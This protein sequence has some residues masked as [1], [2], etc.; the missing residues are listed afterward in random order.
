[1]KAF[2]IAVVT[3]AATVAVAETQ[4]TDLNPQKGTV[5]VQIKPDGTMNAVQLDKSVT[6]DQEA[7]EAAQKAN[8]AA[9]PT[10]KI[11]YKSPREEADDSQPTPGWYR[12]YSGWVAA[13][14]GRGFYPSFGFA[15]ISPFYGYPVSGF[16][17]GGSNFLCYGNPWPTYFTGFPNWGWGWNP[18]GWSGGWLGGWNGG[19][20]GY[21]GGFGGWVGFRGGWAGGWNGGWR[22]GWHHR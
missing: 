9:V 4:I 3:L 19:W 20:L 17:W 8:F 18:Y 21:T 16:A 11:I 5:I 22:G 12:P 7:Q 14:P 13:W 15:N 10:N 1:M 6:S 2:L